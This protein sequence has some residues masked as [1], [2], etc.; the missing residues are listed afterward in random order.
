MTPEELASRL[1]QDAHLLYGVFEQLDSLGQCPPG[2]DWLK[3]YA[4]QR[5]YHLMNSKS[6][7]NSI[8]QRCSLEASGFLRGWI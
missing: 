8:S 6:N 3:E 4:Q 2:L 7:N 1:Y 5:A